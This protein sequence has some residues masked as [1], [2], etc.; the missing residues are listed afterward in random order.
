MRRC[1]LIKH[2][3]GKCISPNG[4]YNHIHQGPNW[5]MLLRS[6]CTQ[7]RDYFCYTEGGSLRHLMG[8]RCL[9][10]QHRKK[11]PLPNESLM[12]ANW[13]CGV[14][15]TLFSFSKGLLKHDASGR[16]VMTQGN[17]PNPGEN[18]RLF[19]SE[20]CD[21]GDGQKFTMDAVKTKRKKVTVQLCVE[22]HTMYHNR[23]TRFESLASSQAECVKMCVNFPHGVCR[24]VTVSPGPKGKKKCQFLDKP[25]GGERIKY[26]P[27]FTSINLNCDKY[28]K[29]YFDYFH[30]NVSF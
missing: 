17:N 29:Y 26:D 16:C 6:K 13:E 19:V 20:A 2:S 4:G 5:H 28:S 11:N 14:S 15:H 8:Q 24:G 7:A 3:G 12:Y 21:G 1:G 27:K 23:G 18:H 22:K 25:F 30:V 9:T 10:T